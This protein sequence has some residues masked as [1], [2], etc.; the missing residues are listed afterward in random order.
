MVDLIPEWA[1]E[2]DKAP[3][4]IKLFTYLEHLGQSELNI[5]F[6]MC[7]VSCIVGP[8]LHF[9]YSLVSRPLEQ[10]R[11]CGMKRRRPG[12]ISLVASTTFNNDN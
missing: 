10:Q 9:T 7:G 1:E 12:L 8:F 6:K 4:W 5:L 2:A 11:V 3:F